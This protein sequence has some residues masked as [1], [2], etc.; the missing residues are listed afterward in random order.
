MAASNNLE[1]I[2]GFTMQSKRFMVKFVSAF[3]NGLL[4]DELEYETDWKD[5]MIIILETLEVFPTSVDNTEQV[6]ARVL[7]DWVKSHEGAEDLNIGV[8]VKME[9]KDYFAPP[10][11]LTKCMRIKFTDKW[12]TEVIFH[13]KKK[14]RMRSLKNIAAAEVV[15]LI[16]KRENIKLLEIPTTLN[17]NLSR[18]FKN[19][20]SSRYYR[21]NIKLRKVFKNPIG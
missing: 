21:K 19:D 13:I 2:P 3:K 8:N 1:T 20:W 6:L 15:D 18:Q 4:S 10:L 9:E 17:A 11:G 7:E 5:V 16:K 14:M 12:N